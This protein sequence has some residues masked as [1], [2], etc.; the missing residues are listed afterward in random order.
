MK[1][2]GK[3]FLNAVL[4]FVQHSDPLSTFPRAGHH[5]CDVSREECNES[6]ELR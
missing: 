6:K 3:G 5:A 4:C 1:E 2:G